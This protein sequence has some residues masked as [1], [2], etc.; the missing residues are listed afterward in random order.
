M[1]RIHGQVES[2]KRLQ[3]ELKSRGIQRFNAINEINDFLNNF[4][5]QNETI[6][7]NHRENLKNEIRDLNQRIKRNLEQKEIAKRKTLIEIEVRI[8]TAKINI[9]NLSAKE[10]KNFISKILN[11]YRL[12]KQKKLLDYLSSNTQ[13]I[14]SKT[15]EGIKKK[16]EKDEK[17]LEYLNENSEQIIRK[18][19]RPEIQKLKN[20]KETL[21]GLNLLIAGAVGESM[22]VKEI[23]KLPDD[24]ILINDYNLKFKKPLYKKNTGEKIF[25]IQIDHLLI[26]K[27]GIYILETKNWSKKSIESPDLR[28]PV[29]QVNRTSYALFV[30]LSKANI[31]PKSVIRN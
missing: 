5:D 20:V 6:I 15:T 29:E 21:E 3:H 11:S 25:S 31:K 28:S 4:R 24:F 27:S 7:R 13:L 16:I 1:A 14:I 19:S 9:D 10:N 23:E 30:V 2:W 18:R 12:K 26:S 8:D 17:Q 22:V